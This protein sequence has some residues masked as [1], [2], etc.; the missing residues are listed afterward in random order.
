MI[1]CKH[2]SQKLSLLICILSFGVSVVFA[3]TQIPGRLDPTF[4]NSG[5]VTTSI[6]TNSHCYD[7][8]VQTDGKIVCVGD[9]HNPNNTLGRSFAAVRYNNDGSLDKSF[10]DG[11]IASVDFSV[12]GI[13]HESTAQSIAIQGDGRLIVAGEV[14]IASRYYFAL[15]RLNTDGSL[16]TSFESDGKVVTQIGFDSFVRSTAIQSDG[17]I[18]AVGFSNNGANIDFAVARYNIDGSLDTSFDDDGKL[19]TAVT[20]GHDYGF[21][22]DVQTDGKIVVCGDGSSDTTIVRYLADGTLDSS[23]SGDGKAVIGIGA[24]D[25]RAKALTLQKDGKIVV[26]GR[27]KISAGGFYNFYVARVSTNGSLDSGFGNN[28][29][30]VT[31]LGDVD[32]GGIAESLAIQSNGKIIISGESQSK[33]AIARF[34]TDGTF[35]TSFDSDGRVLT[36]FPF[37]ASSYASVIQPDGKLVVAG[38]RLNGNFQIAVARYF[39]ECSVANSC[40]EATV[41]GRVLTSDMQ[42]VRKAIVTTVI[43][44]GEIKYAM[45]NPFGYFRFNGL[46]VGDSYTFNILAKGKTFQPVTIK[47]TQGNVNSINLIAN[48]F[49]LINIEKAERN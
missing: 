1:D 34:N 12:N 5:K 13:G 20:A 40:F 22:V 47:L 19:S 11:G 31:P 28:G 26:A 48:P 41:S 33:F 10:G 45:S 49:N 9:A 23:F 18:V 15:A 3:Q 25:S 4:G 6:G 17:K 39:T 36:P 29:K 32:G 43:S 30:V 37:F 16:D 2:I 35:D 14:Q 24:G 21:D 46:V 7:V 27:A 8:H 38:T 44:N 42:P